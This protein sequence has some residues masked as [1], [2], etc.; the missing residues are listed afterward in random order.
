MWKWTHSQSGD[1]MSS[2]YDKWDAL[3]DRIRPVAL[4][5][6]V[7]W[8]LFN[9]I[10]LAKAHTVTV[11]NHH[12]GAKAD[13]NL[14]S[15]KELET[16]DRLAKD[17]REDEVCKI[18]R[19]T[20]DWLHD[21][22]RE[23]DLKRPVIRIVSGYRTKATNK[24]VRGAKSSKHMDCQA[25]DFRIEGLKTRTLFRAARKTQKGGLGYYPH[26]GFI[27]IDSGRTRRW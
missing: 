9:M 14:D 25:L 20:I 15:E 18:D 2:Q 4:V 12:T 16:F 3:F 26:L 23:L 11:V 10:G 22:V 7:L 21:I 13:I 1:F 6:L 5:F 17:W 8:G 27:H 24:K 19:K